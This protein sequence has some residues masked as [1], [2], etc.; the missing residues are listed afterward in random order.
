MALRSGP[1]P[2]ARSSRGQAPLPDGHP[3][4]REDRD[5]PR[6]FW[7]VVLLGLLALCVLHVVGLAWACVSA[8]TIVPI[9]GAVT[10]Q[11][12]LTTD[13]LGLLLLALTWVG[14][15]QQNRTEALAG[16]GP[17]ALHEKVDA[18]AAAHDARAE[19]VAALSAQLDLLTEVLLAGEARRGRHAPTGA[20]P[21]VGGALSHL[22]QRAG[23][24][25]DSP[26]YVPP[27]DV[28]WEQITTGNLPPTT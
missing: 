19:Q 15:R 1:D 27:L 21:V 8:G 13:L 6:A 28:S 12:T 22:T 11:D 25:G 18:V 14:K 9:V 16:R 2:V 3:L 7:R 26:A 20:L 23:E 5:L 24:G 17:A 10:G 4:R